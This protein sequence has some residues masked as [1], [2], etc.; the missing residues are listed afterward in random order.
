MSRFMLAALVSLAFLSACGQVKNEGTDAGGANCTDGLKNGSETDVDCGG[1]SCGACADSR[2]CGGA[3]DCA[4]KVCTNQICQAATCMDAIKNADEVDVDCAGHC[5]NDSCKT[6][7]MCTNNSQCASHMCGGAGT[8]VA[9]KR[10]F[11]TSVGYSGNRG[12][13]AGADLK[14]QGAAVAAG[15]TGNH[16][17]WLSDTTSSAAARLTH[18]TTPYVR[19]DGALVANNWDDLVDGTIAIPINR[20][21]MNTL[22]VSDPVCDNVQNWVFTGT[23]PDGSLLDGSL[24]CGDWTLD[25]GGSAWGRFTTTDSQWSSACT[26]GAPVNYCGRKTPIYC[27]EQ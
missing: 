19:V 18:S 14:C 11:A 20:T 26:G 22:A 1:S 15:L 7:Q 12:G 24:T 27:F 3:T 8:C 23:R 25:T 17:A 10:V 4:S 13:L 21:E 2:A 6:G 5:G 9:A 16:Q